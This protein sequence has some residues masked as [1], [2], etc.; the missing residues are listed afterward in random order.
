[1][2]VSPHYLDYVL[3]QL[4]GVGAITS[5]RMFGGVGIYLDGLFFALIDDD[6]LYFKV[7]SSNRADYEATGMGPFKPFG[8]D[9]HVMNYYEVPIEILEDRDRLR[10]WAERARAV[11]KAKRPS[12]KKKKQKR[13][14]K[15]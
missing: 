5:K 13:K 9:S 2:S 11:A 15:A 14:N 12:G 7:D 6:T 10:L 3:E 8:D 4:S 1:M